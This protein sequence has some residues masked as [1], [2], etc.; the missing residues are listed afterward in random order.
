MAVCMTVSSNEAGYS[1]SV[2]S[3]DEDLNNSRTSTS[4][5]HEAWPHL[6]PSIDAATPAWPYTT[7]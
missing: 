2:M 3:V 5:V 4:H 6:V 1:N 7:L